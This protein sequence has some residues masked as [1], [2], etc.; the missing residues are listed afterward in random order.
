[1]KDLPGFVAQ[2]PLIPQL[3][4]GG[5]VRFGNIDLKACLALCIRGWCIRM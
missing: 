5:D 1:M 4:E 3:K 2:V